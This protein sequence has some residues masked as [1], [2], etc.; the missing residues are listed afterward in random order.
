MF[1]AGGCNFRDPDGRKCG[2]HIRVEAHYRSEEHAIEA[3]IKKTRFAD[4]GGDE[5]MCDAEGS[6]RNH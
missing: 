3:I 1:G 5:I 2:R 4:I 6:G